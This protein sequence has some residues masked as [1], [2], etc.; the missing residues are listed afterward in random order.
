MLME[1]QG[2]LGFVHPTHAFSK[3]EARQLVLPSAA[4]RDPW[5]VRSP[6]TVQMMASQ[7][8]CFAVP[9]AAQK[10]LSGLTTRMVGPWH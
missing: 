3:S 1:G 8:A 9:L 5:R 6:V 7:L 4:P 2:F 10:R